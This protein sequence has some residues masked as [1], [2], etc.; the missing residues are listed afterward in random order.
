MTLSQV[1]Q[2]QDYSKRTQI[3]LSQSMYQR[4]MK[5]K[6][7]ESLAKL[8]RKIIVKHW[9][10]KENKMKKRQQAIQTLIQGLPGSGPDRKKLV[11]WQRRIRREKDSDE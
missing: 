9:Q 6:G 8:I 7:Q 4:L 11:T 1:L 3:S 10:T 5:E 2:D